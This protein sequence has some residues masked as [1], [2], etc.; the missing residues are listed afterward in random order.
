[1]TSRWCPAPIDPVPDP[2]R[3]GTSSLRTPRLELRPDDDAGLLELVDVAYAGVHPPERDAVPARRGPTPIRATSA[4]GCCSTSGRSG[5]RWRPE[6]W[7]L[8]FLV[9]RRRPGDRHAEPDRRAASACC[10]RSAPAPGWAGSTRAGLGTE[11]RAA[12]L[13]FAFDHLGAQRARSTAFSDNAASLPGLGRAGLPPRRHAQPS[14]RRGGQHSVIRLL[15][16]RDRLRPS[17]T[18]RCEVDGCRAVPCRCWAR[19]DSAEV[20]A[21][22]ERVALRRVAALVAGGA[23]TSRAAP[24]CRG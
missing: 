10:V 14:R 4:A 12:V 24:S 17:A 22:G 13:Q 5:P 9:R 21:A 6:R 18:G 20:D 2:G 3:C 11:M 7:A 23:T 16:D 8:H 19:P 15:L 1:M